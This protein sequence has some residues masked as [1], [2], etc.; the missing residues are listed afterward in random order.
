MAFSVKSLLAP[1]GGL[2]GS[3][4]PGVGTAL[5]SA[6]GS[7]LGGG[8]G[9][10]MGS[11]NSATSQNPQLM[12]RPGYPQGFTQGQIGGRDVTGIPNFNPQQMS[13]LNQLLSSGL[14]GMSNLQGL[15]DLPSASFG[16]VKEQAMSNFYQNIVPGIAE[17]FTGAGAGGQRSSAFGQQLGSA[18]ANLAGQLGS[19]EQM[20]NMQQRQNMLGE[21]GQEINRLMSM[22][23][24]GLAPQQQYEFSPTDPGFAKS[25]IAGAGPAI[26]GAAKHGLPLLRDYLKTSYP[27]HFGGF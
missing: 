16:P 22:L 8:L 26:A 25:A 4:V 19:Q 12:N 9:Y 18:G 11:R 15:G 3:F 17:Q 23:Q 27:Q 14:G 6:G 2:L 7:L 13:A 24:M 5:G 10:L 1:L 20:F 21:R